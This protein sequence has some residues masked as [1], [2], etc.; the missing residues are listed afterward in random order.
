MRKDA[1]GG[2]GRGNF[3]LPLRVIF[4]ERDG[5]HR[6]FVKFLFAGVLNTIVG[7]LSFALFF[8]LFQHKE[9]ALTLSLLVGIVF[10]YHS[11]SRIVFRDATGRSILRFIGVFI[12]IYLLGLAHLWVLVDGLS[13]NV[14]LAQF[15]ALTYMPL[16]AFALNKKFVY[17][18]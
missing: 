5:E 10:N 18:T 8:F 17:T 6:R 4:L 2:R 9:L 13:L 12:L 1:L 16:V 11:Y 7:Y 14:Y 3:V 15:L